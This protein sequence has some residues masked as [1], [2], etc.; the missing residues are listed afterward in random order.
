MGAA[1]L[2]GNGKA[3]FPLISIMADDTQFWQQFNNLTITV[4]RMDERQKVMADDVAHLLE[5]EGNRS[6]QR[7]ADKEWRR[8]IED[9]LKAVEGSGIAAWSWKKL[10]QA[11][12]L[13]S[14]CGVLLGAMFEFSRWIASHW[15]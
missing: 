3:S 11:V 13:V 5:L 2:K 8:G 9:R 1:I 6:A 7:D 10:A 14:G 4:A 12:A 15:K